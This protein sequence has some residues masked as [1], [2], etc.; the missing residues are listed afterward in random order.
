MADK[1]LFGR[2]SRLFSTNIIVR[3]IGGRRLKVADTS[4]L[5][6]SGNLSSNYMVD[7]WAKLH[8]GSGYGSGAQQTNYTVARRVLF[9]DYEA[10]DQ[11]PIL[12]SA[13]DIYSD[14]C[15]VRNE[16]GNILE[17][18][19]TN[20]NIQEIL[21]N[22]FYDILNIDF[23]LWPWIRNLV[24]YGDHFMKLDI[25]EK[26]GIVNV[27]P[28]SPY[29]ME[30]VEEFDTD[31]QRPV[32]F[33]HEGEG[34]KHEYENYEIAHFR[35]LSDTNFLPYG[36][37]MI[38][39][40]RKIWKQ[41]VLMEDAMLLHRIMRAPE[42]RVFKIDIGNIPPAEVDT[43]MNSLISKM[44][45]TP[46]IDQAT[47]DYNLKY[48]MQN[49]LEDFYLP[50]RGGDTGTSIE[51]LAGLENNSIDDIEYLKNKMLAALK[52][53]KAFLGYEEGVEG[54][55]TLAQED[56]RFA[57]TIERI[58]RIVESELYKIAIV[59]LYAQGYKDAELVNFDLA[60]TNPS[61]VYEQEKIELW[62]NKQSLAS[63]LKDLKMVSEDWVY[64][65]I[66]NM[67]TDQVKKER[68]RV[69]EDIKRKFRHDQI[70]AE[71]NDPV[72][73]GQSF[74]TPHDL[75]MVGQ[76]GQ[77]EQG[78]GAGGEEDPDG[79]DSD[80]KVSIFAQDNRGA[81]K[82]GHPGA[83]RPKKGA[84]YKTDRGARG[85]D[86]IGA[87]QNKSLSRN[88]TI[89]HTYNGSPMRDWYSKHKSKEIITETMKNALETPYNDEGGL[90][91]EKNLIS[92]EP[93]VE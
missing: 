33:F 61:I 47:G 28:I 52:I 90:L 68:E 31:V 42:K 64:G 26:Y 80:D 17:I 11:D 24:K 44:K 82:G 78:Q 46:F 87:K 84:K 93:N 88:K 12:S 49:M 67:S 36:K 2:L 41:L 19:S 57:R 65:N 77:I 35:L 43:Y 76:E 51:N 55:S 70:E 69:I 30:R 6:S 29:E 71:G 85:R 34:Q 81:P 14:E 56:V 21:N 50:V 54:K 13:L 23:N 27:N 39:A 91:D 75:A 7:R 9:D 48:N 5:Q 40:A 86:P 25:S 3:N 10:M 8:R 53:P 45:K 38:E 60:L 15:T 83:G 4:R 16:F 18:T 59:H 66:F 72:T 79:Y 32:M 58:Q 37:S 63:D 89:K 62:N 20:D 1:S 73:T 22:L 74:G 92:D